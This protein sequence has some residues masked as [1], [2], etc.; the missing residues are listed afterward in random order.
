MPR[1]RLNPPFKLRCKETY[2]AVIPSAMQWLAWSKLIE[3]QR[4]ANPSISMWDRSAK[5]NANPCSTTSMR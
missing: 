1:S 3:A 4:S 5:S 2:S